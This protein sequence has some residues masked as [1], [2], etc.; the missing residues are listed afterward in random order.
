MH[1]RKQFLHLMTFRRNYP[2]HL[3]MCRNLHSHRFPFGHPCLHINL[4]QQLFHRLIFRNNFLLRYRIFFPHCLLRRLISTQIRQ[5]HDIYV[6]RKLLKSTPGNHQIKVS[7]FLISGKLLDRGINIQ[8]NFLRF[9]VHHISRK[10]LTIKL[11]LIT[12]GNFNFLQLHTSLLH[13]QLPAGFRWKNE[14]L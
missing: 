12:K 2:D 11:V 1:H 7:H 8:L 3:P 9:M 6:R 13:T 14:F 10:A 5:I 4:M